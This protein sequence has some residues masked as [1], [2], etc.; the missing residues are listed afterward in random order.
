MRAYVFDWMPYIMDVITMIIVISARMG[1]IMED[2]LRDRLDDFNRLS[3]TPEQCS[4][5]KMQ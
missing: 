4:S 1:G 3:S 5:K 2:P